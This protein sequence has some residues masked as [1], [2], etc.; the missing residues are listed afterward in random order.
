MRRPSWL[1]CNCVLIDAKN[2]LIC[3]VTSFTSFS[4]KIDNH[5]L[6]SRTG[7]QISFFSFLNWDKNMETVNMMNSVQLYSDFSHNI[8]IF[9]VYFIWRK[10]IKK[11]FKINFQ[12]SAVSYVKNW[13]VRINPQVTNVIHIYIYIYIY[14]YDIISLR[15]ND[16]TLIVL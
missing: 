16:L 5:R 12:V 14:I 2:R 8:F 7:P 1:P 3:E 4:K 11:S 9:I 10:K 15:V 6:D 13:M